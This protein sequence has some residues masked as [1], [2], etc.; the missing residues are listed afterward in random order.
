MH[1]QDPDRTEN[2]FII[3]TKT[4]NATIKCASIPTLRRMCKNKHRNT[5]K[6]KL[7]KNSAAVSTLLRATREPSLFYTFSQQV[8]RDALLLYT[9]KFMHSESIGHIYSTM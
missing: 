6:T 9:H 3:A 7:Q 2:D 1:I 4:I 5:L 8:D